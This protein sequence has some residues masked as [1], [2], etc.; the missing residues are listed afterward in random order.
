MSPDAAIAE[1]LTGLGQRPL[2]VAVSG[3]GD[4][5]ALLHLLAGK[6]DL[7]AITIN[8]GLRPEAAAEAAGVAADCVRLGVPHQV[9]DW[10][11]DGTGNLSD[12]ARRGRIALIAQWALARGIADVVLGHTADDQAETFLMRLA[13]GSGVDGLSAMSDQRLAQGVMWH[14]PVLGI[15]RAALRDWLKAQ[16]LAWVDDPTND[17]AAYLRVRARAALAALAPLGITVETL[18]DAAK[19]QAM[20]SAA[21]WQVAA[22][23]AR[24]IARVDG[25]DVVF[26]RAGMIALPL[27]TQLRLLAH[28]VMCV[29]S[30][31]YRPRLSALAQVHAAL[32]IGRKRTLGGCL[33]TG[34]RQVLRVAREWQAVAAV[35]CGAGEVWDLRWQLVG[36]DSNGLHIAALGEAGLAVVPDWRGQGVPRTS[37]IASPAVWHGA[38]LVAAPLAGM[39]NGWCAELAQ[40]ADS[41]F[42][43]LLS[44]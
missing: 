41:F 27:E 4:S 19:L 39:A 21:L 20:A 33:L 38:D 15:R 1:F 16:G 11:W 34:N 9:L 14:R 30:A 26:D 8:H 12:A 7:A 44:H 29:S 13:R 35:R 5:T 40:G 42:T 23:A 32:V 24:K 36:P 3:G 37:L 31:I 22:E 2:A 10:R 28:A 18:F 25:G 17:D 6:A 43:T